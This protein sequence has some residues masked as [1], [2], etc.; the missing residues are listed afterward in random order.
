MAACAHY[1]RIEYHD[2]TT[3]TLL[4]PMPYDESMRPLRL[5]GTVWNQM[6]GAAQAHGGLIQERWNA[7]EAR[8]FSRAVRAAL[9][10]PTSTP[11]APARYAV[12]VTPR[13]DH[14]LPLRDPEVRP[15]VEQALSLFDVG[16]VLAQRTTESALR[17]LPHG[18][19]PD[20]GAAC[21]K[22]P[23]VPQTRR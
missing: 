11:T 15:L 3:D 17:A 2:M 16:A 4:F 8:Q 20:T 23:V 9:E 21:R 22:S 12:F 19:T 6:L 14:G 5:P 7:T 13:V 18:N 1:E 10:T